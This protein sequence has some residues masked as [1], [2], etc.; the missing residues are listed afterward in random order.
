MDRLNFEDYQALAEAANPPCI[1]IYLPTH[2]SGRE[3]QGDPTRLKN[4]LSHAE[5]QLTERPMRPTLARDLLQ[6]ARELLEEPTFWLYS[7]DALAVFIAEGFF[8][9]YRLPLQTEELMVVN[10]RF[11]LKPLLPILAS[12]PFHVLAVSLNDVRLLECRR[13][14]VERVKLPDD[15]ATRYSAAIGS[16]DH[17]ID[18]GLWRHGGGTSAQTQVTQAHGH[19]PDQ[20][21]ELRENT[22]FFMRQLDEGVTRVIGD[23]TPLI[24]AGADSTW[25]DFMH[26]T[27]RKNVVPHAI[28]GNPEH[29]PDETLREKALEIMEPIWQLE[30]AELGERFGTAQAHGIASS[31]VVEILRAASE[32]RVETLVVSPTVAVWGEY[33]EGENLAREG[34]KASEDLVEVAVRQTL[35]TNG[36]VVVAEGDQVPGEREAAAIFRY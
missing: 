6:P 21:P 34:G 28:P 24:V 13:H 9:A 25:P 2:R 16:K 29:V 20:E 23:E 27:K 32:G 36:L 22:A 14:S 10:D 5:E 4:L 30:F 11:Q 18:R 35:R 8:R 31:D 19:G 12:R 15:V 33:D 26:A 7:S 3:T 1:S 17:H